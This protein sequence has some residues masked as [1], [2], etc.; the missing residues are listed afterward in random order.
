MS[1]RGA[2]HRPL[3]VRWLVAFG[4]FWVDFLIGDTPELFV[5]GAAAVGAAAALAA[6]G[7]RAAAVAILPVVVLVVLTGSLLRAWRRS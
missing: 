2:D 4:R 7:Q 1:D 3:P 6:G 5:G